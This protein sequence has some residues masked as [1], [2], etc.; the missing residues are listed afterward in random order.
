[1]SFDS[2]LENKCSS[3][4]QADYWNKS[5]ELDLTILQFCKSG[6]SVDFDLHVESLEQVMPWITIMDHH[7]YA[8]N[9][10]VYIRDLSTLKDRHPA[11]HVEF[12]NGNF[13]AQKTLRRFSRI[14]FDH[15]HEQGIDWLKNLSGVIWNLNDPRA[16]CCEQVSRPEMARLIDELEGQSEM[17][18]DKHHEQFP[19]FQKKI[20]G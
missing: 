7:H 4:A 11:I 19:Q 13:T 10:P 14:M 3:S 17:K 12:K 2:W 15:C 9:L 20:Y 16:V 18:T 5:K 6:H 1:M 8:R